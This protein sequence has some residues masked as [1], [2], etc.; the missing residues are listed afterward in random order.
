MKGISIEA[1]VQEAHFRHY[2][3]LFSQRYP[4]ASFKVSINTDWAHIYGQN[5]ERVLNLITGS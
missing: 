2:I 4:I 1:P 5:V 3:N